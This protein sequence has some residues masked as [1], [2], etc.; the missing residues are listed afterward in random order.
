[1]RVVRPIWKKPFLFSVFRTHFLQR[2]NND[3]VRAAVIP[4]N[5]SPPRIAH[6]PVARRHRRNRFITRAGS[7]RAQSFRV[8]VIF[9]KAFPRKCPFRFF[10]KQFFFFAVLRFP[11]AV[12]VARGVVF[13]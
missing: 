4:R 12:A 13:D 11:E 5:R 3:G 2:F 9:H 6:S 10:K 7:R 1:M 8:R